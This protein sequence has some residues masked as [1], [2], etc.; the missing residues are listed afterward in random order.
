M[1]GEPYTKLEGRDMYKAVCIY[2]KELRSSAIF[3]KV[4]TEDEEAIE[5]YTE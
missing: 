1:K 5:I 2:R 4:G 3:D